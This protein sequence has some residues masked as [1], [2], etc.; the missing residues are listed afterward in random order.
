MNFTPKKTQ[1]SQQI[2]I[3]NDMLVGIEI[4]SGFIVFNVVRIHLS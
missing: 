3:V 2:Q 1:E 4:F